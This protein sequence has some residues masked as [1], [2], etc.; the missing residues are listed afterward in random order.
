MYYFSK[1]SESHLIT[2]D[3][4]LQRLMR[5]VIQIFDISIIRG[6]RDEETQNEAYRQGFS[7]KQYP[8]SKHNVNPSLAID[9]APYPIDWKDNERFYYLAGFV[10]MA[11]YLLNIPIRWGGD[12][13]RDYDLHDQTLYDFGHFELM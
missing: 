4:N 12:W 9:I 11:A 2:C 6:Y 5:T 7:T 1:Q 13:D 10:G 3:E 8:H